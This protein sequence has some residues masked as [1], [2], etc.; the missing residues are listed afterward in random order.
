VGGVSAIKSTI[1]SCFQ[2]FPRLR[3]G[4]QLSDRREWGPATDHQPKRAALF[5]LRTGGSLDRGLWV[6]AAAVIADRRRALSQVEASHTQRVA[7]EISSVRARRRAS[8][9]AQVVDALF[10]AEFR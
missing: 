2:R 6:A 1:V 9:R 10:T 3:V 5:L 4:F 8:P 7:A